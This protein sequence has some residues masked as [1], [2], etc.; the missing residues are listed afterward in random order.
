MP[1]KGYDS[2]GALQGAAFSSSLG[3]NVAAWDFL[4]SSAQAIPLV[5][6]RYVLVDVNAAAG[7]VVV[8]LP[9]PNASGPTYCGVKIITAANGKTVTVQSSTGALVDVLYVEEEAIQVAWDPTSAKWQIIAR[10]QHRCDFASARFAPVGNWQLDGLTANPQ[11][12]SGNARHLVREATFPTVRRASGVRSDLCADSYGRAWNLY[13]PAFYLLGNV[14]LE[15]VCR[16]NYSVG[17][18]GM[19]WQYGDGTGGSVQNLSWGLEIYNG[20]AGAG[21]FF[22]RHQYGA[23]AAAG[24]QSGSEAYLSFE[25]THVVITR[26]AWT[27]A[28]HPLNFYV[29]GRLVMATTANNQAAGGQSTNR[30]RFLGGG[31]N[32]DMQQMAVYSSVLTAAQ[33]RYLA[34]LRLGGRRN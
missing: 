2:S 22:W 23:N 1:G 29:N 13:D 21:T 11:D 14:S 34:K 24:I 9:A 18:T 25:W 19:L 20:S 15:L 28:N 17:V 32:L 31:P 33:V 12:T 16:G 8:T 30:M 6:R 3:S 5:H 27:G 10:D 7:D 4:V 26:G